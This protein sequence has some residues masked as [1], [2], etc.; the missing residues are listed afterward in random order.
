MNRE[1]END[2]A[3]VRENERVKHRE[4]NKRVKEREKAKKREKKS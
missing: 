2:W 3:K 1:R 4:K